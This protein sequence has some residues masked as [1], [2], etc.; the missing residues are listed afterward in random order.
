[1]RDI[2]KTYKDLEWIATSYALPTQDGQYLVHFGG[3]YAVMRFNS[4]LRRW[5]AISDE[6]EKSV[7]AGAVDYWAQLSDE[8]VFA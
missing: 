8:E 2:I 6:V 7:H 3:G 4:N 1:M 5:S